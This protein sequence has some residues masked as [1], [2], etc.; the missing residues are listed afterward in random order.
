MGGAVGIVARTRI[1]ANAVGAHRRPIPKRCRHRIAG[2]RCF[3][4]AGHN[5][6]HV[7]RRKKVFMKFFYIVSCN[8]SCG[9]RVAITAPMKR[10]LL[11]VAH[12]MKSHAAH[13]LRAVGAF[14][15]TGQPFGTF[16]LQL[17]FREH[18]VANHIA[19]QVQHQRHVFGQAFG[20][21]ASGKHAAAHAEVGPNRLGLF[22][23]LFVRKSLGATHQTVAH[24]ARQAAFQWVGLVQC[25]G[26][27]IAVHNDSGASEVFVGQHADAVAELKLRDIFAIGHRGCRG[28]FGF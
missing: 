2:L 18:R 16:F 14:L 20:V 1:S 21:K 22:K 5:D 6:D 19:Q 17:S 24:K 4:C 15:Q 3:Y 27:Q 25:T 26:H 10:V 13:A 12:L 8:G 23:Y 11:W 28:D 7:F 9:L